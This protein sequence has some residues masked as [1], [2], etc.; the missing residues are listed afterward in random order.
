MNDLGL[1]L[2]Y[3][4][5]AKEGVR[6]AQ[7][8]MRLN[9]HYPEFYTMQIGQIYFD[10]RLYELAVAALESLRGEDTVL[11]CLYL[12][13]SHAA[14]NH[15]DDAKRAVKRALLVEPTAKRSKWASLELAPYKK[16]LDLE[17]LRELLR[18]AGLP[19]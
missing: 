10:A 19:E 6:L 17:H 16:A 8:A 9:P 2:S 13:A 3:A 1:C 12:A 18:R 5:E 11:A 7:K 15:T 14:L 4:G